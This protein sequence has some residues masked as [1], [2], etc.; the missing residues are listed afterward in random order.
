MAS[1]N[2]HSIDEK[3]CPYKCI[4][5]RGDWYPSNVYSRDEIGAPTNVHSIDE[6]D[7]PVMYILEMRLVPLQ[8]SI[9]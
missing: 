9:L 6:I 7:A 1:T 4:F 8:M 5:Y 3:Q 2:V